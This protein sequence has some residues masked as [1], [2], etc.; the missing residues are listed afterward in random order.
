MSID[1]GGAAEIWD[2]IHAPLH[3]RVH[4]LL[5]RVFAEHLQC[6]WS[7]PTQ[8]RRGLLGSLSHGFA[9]GGQHL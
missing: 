6:I 7:L 9:G 3:S 1:T 4:T 8:G 5:A 2:V